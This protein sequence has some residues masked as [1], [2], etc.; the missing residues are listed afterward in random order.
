MTAGLSCAL[1]VLDLAALVILRIR[2][3]EKKHARMIVSVVCG[4]IAF[5]LGGYLALTALFLDAAYHK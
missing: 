5:A 2:L 4:L 3:R 1:L